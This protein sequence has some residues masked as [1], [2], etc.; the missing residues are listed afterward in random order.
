MTT[1]RPYQNNQDTSAK[2]VSQSLSARTVRDIKRGELGTWVLTTH[3]GYYSLPA[4][5]TLSY[6]LAKEFY[7]HEVG[8][9][10]PSIDRL[11]RDFGQ[12]TRTIKRWIAVIRDAKDENGKR[13]WRV[14]R[15]YVTKGGKSMANRYYPLFLNDI[16]KG[17]PPVEE[18]EEDKWMNWEVEEE[19]LNDVDGTEDG[20]AELDADTDT[21]APAT[22]ADSENDSEN[23]I[24]PIP[25]RYAQSIEV[26]ARVIARLDIEPIRAPKLSA[27][28]Q[29]LIQQL[30]AYC[31]H[32]MDLDESKK[33]TFQKMLID[34]WTENPHITPDAFYSRTINYA[35]KEWRP[36]F[37]DN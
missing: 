24:Q 26:M 9:A 36:Q 16:L 19:F 5:F 27:E 12:S 17:K 31:T 7:N 11:A 10:F 2:N 1:N 20:L 28:K 4:A 18:P 30:V 32:R 6:I 33:A 37:L 21:D 23:I 35:V 13:L 3:A 25:S 14:D 22:S 29:L 34:R 8:Y 15:G